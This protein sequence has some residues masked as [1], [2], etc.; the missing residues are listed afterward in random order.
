MGWTTPFWAKLRSKALPAPCELPLAVRTSQDVHSVVRAH[1][2]LPDVGWAK[3]WDIS[4]A[5]E[6]ISSSYLH[7][8]RAKTSHKLPVLA[9][10][11]QTAVNTSEA[12]LL[13]QESKLQAS[14]KLSAGGKL[15]AGS[16]LAGFTPPSRGFRCVH[17]TLAQPVAVP[18]IGSSC[19]ADASQHAVLVVW[20]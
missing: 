14:S 2:C 19:G 11:L 12:S 17:S 1:D 4:S 10:M 7:V 16:K 20:A 3:D 15:S 9:D 8:R 18:V 6:Y 13:P 5:T